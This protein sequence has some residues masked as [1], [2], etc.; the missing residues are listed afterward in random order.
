MLL[1]TAL[2]LVGQ[3]QALGLHFQRLIRGMQRIADGEFSHRIAPAGPREIG[4]IATSFNRMLDSIQKTENELQMN[5][6]KQIELENQLRHAEKLAAIGQLAA[7]VA[8]ELGAPLSII[9]GTAQRELRREPLHCG[10]ASSLERIRREVGRMEVIIHQLLEFS[11]SRQLKPRKLRPAQVARSAA[12]A[13]A[14]ET[15]A[16]RAQ[17]KLK[18][19]SGTPLFMADPIRLEQVLVNLLRNAVQAGKNINVVL[20]WRSV[21]GKMFFTVDDNGPGVPTKIRSRLFEP[22]FTTK[23]VGAGTGLGLAVVHGIVKEHG[24]SVRVEKSDLGGARFE[25]ALPLTF[26]VKDA[27]A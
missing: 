27:T 23:N 18:G 10:S 8:H 13:I 6:R 14:E 12:A 11:H 3:N 1:M 20:G 5:R 17:V 15:S 22:F 2:V 16:N 24:G 4:S 26:C 9:S 25:V 21:D 7:G 19:D